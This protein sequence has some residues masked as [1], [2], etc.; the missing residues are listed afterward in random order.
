MARLAAVAVWS[1]LLLFPVLK[2]TELELEDGCEADGCEAEVS[3]ALQLGR[4]E[5]EDDLEP[6]EDP[7]IRR[8]IWRRNTIRSLMQRSVNRCAVTQDSKLQSLSV[9]VLL[10]SRF[11]AI[12]APARA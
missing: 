2:G 4:G 10:L 11:P 7:R 12:T 6:A 5:D 3:S 9:A 8:R 1:C